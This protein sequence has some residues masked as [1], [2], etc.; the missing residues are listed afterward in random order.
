MQTLLAT[1]LHQL[2]HF[3]FLYVGPSISGCTYVL[4][5]KDDHTNY[6]WLRACKNADGDSAVQAILEMQRI[7]HCARLVI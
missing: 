2:L 6:A 5:L 3:D 1:V 4:I 7:W